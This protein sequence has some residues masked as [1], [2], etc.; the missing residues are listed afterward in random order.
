MA[1]SIARCGPKE[2]NRQRSEKG[3]QETAN[4]EQR[5]LYLAAL[6]YAMLL[7]FKGLDWNRLDEIGVVVN[8]R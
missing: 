8:G 4:E 2:T 1:R 5:V 7:V 6:R 3:K